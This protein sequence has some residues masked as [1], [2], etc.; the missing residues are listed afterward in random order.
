MDS[1]PNVDPLLNKNDPTAN[2]TVNVLEIMPGHLSSLLDPKNLNELSAMG[3]VLG[4]AIRLGINIHSGPTPCQRTILASHYGKN[5]LAPKKAPS[6]F[7]MILE[8]FLDKML[9]L[10]TAAA[11]V[12]LSIGIYEDII[13]KTL[14]HWI[15]GAAILF[16]VLL[17]VMANAL[18]DYQREKQF[19]RLSSSAENRLIK[20]L[21]KEG[22]KQISIFDLVVG[23]I[24]LFEPGVKNYLITSLMHHKF[25][26]NITS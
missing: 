6:F 21:S 4:I 2:T 3:G 1:S 16:A 19:R 11:L 14:T 23:D 5:R 25:V 22:I 20:V 10:L 26:G 7:K 17:V 24:L 13:N 8:A 15:E 18:N 12:S 9:L